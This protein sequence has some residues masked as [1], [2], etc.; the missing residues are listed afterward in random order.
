MSQTDTVGRHFYQLGNEQWNIPQLRQLLEKVLPE[1]TAVKD[2]SVTH[3]F[4]EI[5]Q[6]TMLVSGKRVDDVR[7][8]VPPVIFL[9]IEDVTERE[10]ASLPR[11][12]WLLWLNPR[13][14][15]SSRKISAE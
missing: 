1:K 5:G 4:P 14:M 2:F 13:T 12:G 15:P 7:G 3:D 6:K 9:A 11:R 8:A 10:L